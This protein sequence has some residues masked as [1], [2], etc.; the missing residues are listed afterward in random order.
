MIV[1]ECTEYTAHRNSSTA[2]PV[3]IPRS[4]LPKIVTELLFVQKIMRQWVPKQQIP[5]HKAKRMESALTI[6]V[7]L[8]LHL[9]KCLFGQRQRFKNDKEGEMSD[10]K[11]L[12]SQ[13]SDF[14]DTG[15][16]KRSLIL[17]NVSIPEVNTLANSSTLPVSVPIN[18]SIKLCFFCKRSQ[19]NLLCGHATYIIITYLNSFTV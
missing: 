7:N 2:V 13:A 6:V 10:I 1:S 4:L 11:R 15:I 17:T 9:K 12:Q 14:S 18:L 16:Q 3:V 19:G 8:F 5:E